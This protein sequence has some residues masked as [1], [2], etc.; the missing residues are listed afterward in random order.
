MFAELRL[1]K[2]EVCLEQIQAG[3]EANIHFNTVYFLESKYKYEYRIRDARARPIC[4]LGR[5]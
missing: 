4:H 1:S 2:S 5:A 3:G